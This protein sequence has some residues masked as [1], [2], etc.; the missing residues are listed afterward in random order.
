MQFCG[1]CGSMMHTD[2]D[3]WVC[4]S[5][6]N[7]APRD[8]KAESAMATREG[9][10]DDGAPAVADTTQGATETVREPCPAADCDSEDAS[11]EMMPKPGGSY[12]VRLFTC[13]ECGHKWRES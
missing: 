8:S 2:D 3:R 9:Q 13:V 4:R 12:E 11:Y 1:G 7:E 10:Q 5:C 6:G